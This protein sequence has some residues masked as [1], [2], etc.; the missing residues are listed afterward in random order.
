MT[1]IIEEKDMQ[2]IDDICSGFTTFK[3]KH[4]SLMLAYTENKENN[5]YTCDNQEARAVLLYALHIG[6]LYH[7]RSLIR[8][9]N[10]IDINRINDLLEFI[11]DRQTRATLVDHFISQSD[12]NALR[13]IATI[14]DKVHVSPYDTSTSYIQLGWTSREIEQIIEIFHLG[15]AF[16]DL[17]NSCLEHQKELKK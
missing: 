5:F 9:E 1:Y 14:W 16:R 13:I 17:F 7:F 4:I 11:T 2:L 15:M 8:T 10:P 6:D 3:E 12:F